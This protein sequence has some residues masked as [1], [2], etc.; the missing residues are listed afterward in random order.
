M[1]YIVILE[2]DVKQ[3]TAEEF[4]RSINDGP[5]ESRAVGVYRVPTQFCSCMSDA[6]EK[7]KAWSRGQKYGWWIHRDCGKPSTHWATGLGSRMSSV[8][9]RNLLGIKAPENWQDPEL[10]SNRDEV[11]AQESVKGPS[12]YQPIP[13]S[14]RDAP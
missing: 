12:K 5:L 3:S 9:G 14:K 10:T 4:A 13:R 1:P 8:L 6:K 7:M 11:L 2:M